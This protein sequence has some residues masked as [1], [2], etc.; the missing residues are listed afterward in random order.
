LIRGPKDCEQ[1]REGGQRRDHSDEHRRHAAVPHG[2]QEVHGEE[3]EAGQRER[4]CD[5]RDHDRSAGG[6]DGTGQRRRRVMPAR[7]APL[8]SA[9][10]EQRVVDRHAEAEHRDDVCRKYRHLGQGGEQARDR[11]RTEDG[12]HT[13]EHRRGRGDQATE[14]EDHEYEQDRHRD[15]F[16]L[17]DVRLDLGV[18]V[19]KERQ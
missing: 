14:D 11:E 10:D 13:H 17:H 16:G 6:G 9:H 12:E 3:K 5:A 19:V 15:Q 7:V 4:D 2:F 8:G 1:R 18:R